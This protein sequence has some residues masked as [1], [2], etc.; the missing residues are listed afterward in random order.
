M[1]DDAIKCIKCTFNGCHARTF[2]PYTD[3]WA[4]L[5]AWGP[6]I[7]DGWY[8]GPHAD[9]IERVCGLDEPQ[10]GTVQ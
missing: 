5:A 10:H 8:C 9:A 1:S 4:S 2:Q 6:G 7:L 3:G